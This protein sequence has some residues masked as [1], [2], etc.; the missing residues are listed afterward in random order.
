MKNG[1]MPKWGT[2]NYYILEWLIGSGSAITPL[3]AL[4]HCGC[5][6]LSQRIIELEALGWKIIRARVKTSGGATVMS[7][8]LEN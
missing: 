1:T 4:E 5:F 8:K 2:Q 3:K 7:Y 6:R